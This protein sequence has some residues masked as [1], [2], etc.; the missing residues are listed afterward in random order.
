M[1][2]LPL[3]NI[4]S[5]CSVSFLG[6][7]L[8]PPLALQVSYYLLINIVETALCRSLVLLCPLPMQAAA[9]ASD[10]VRQVTDCKDPRSSSED[11]T[12]LIFGDGW[13]TK[14]RNIYLSCT[15]ACYPSLLVEVCLFCIAQRIWGCDSCCLSYSSPGPAA[16][17]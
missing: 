10:D 5:D 16:D 12:W 1:Y 14:G 15:A 8:A 4:Q 3:I 9:F 7:Y 6:A 17:R 13:G 11:L 2:L